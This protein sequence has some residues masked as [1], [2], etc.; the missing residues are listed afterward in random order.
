MSGLSGFIAKA[1]FLVF[2]L[3][4]S[5]TFVFS[6]VGPVIEKTGLKEERIAICVISGVDIKTCMGAN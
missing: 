2:L 1:S 3:S 4:A 6:V 5:F